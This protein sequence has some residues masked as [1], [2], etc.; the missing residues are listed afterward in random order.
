[1]YREYTEQ[2]CIAVVETTILIAMLLYHSSLPSV[3]FHP[4]LQ[5]PK[6]R[7]YCQSKGNFID[8]TVG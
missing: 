8:A 4:Y 5:Q 1:M 6:L 2:P 3:E 7:K